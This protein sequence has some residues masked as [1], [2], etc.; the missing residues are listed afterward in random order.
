M[1]GLEKAISIAGGKRSLALA[2]E[3]KPSSLSRWIHRYKGRVPPGRLIQIFKLTGV[4]PHEL[5]PDL[6]PTPTSG[7]PDCV[8]LTRNNNQEV[9]NDDHP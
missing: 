7:I 3:I 1:N 5:R 9:N 2:L 6:H 8:T 4:T